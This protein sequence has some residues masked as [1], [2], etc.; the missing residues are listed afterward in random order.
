V[1][2]G[3]TG[4]YGYAFLRGDQTCLRTST[5]MRERTS[6]VVISKETVDAAA[7]ATA[8]M[9]ASLA[10]NERLRTKRKAR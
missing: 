2:P 4:R 1:L 7:P 10:L 8:R 9:E 5:P 6:V 3:F